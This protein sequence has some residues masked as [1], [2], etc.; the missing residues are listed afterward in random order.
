MCTSTSTAAA[1]GEQQPFFIQL[2]TLAKAE[3]QEVAAAE[4]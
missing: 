2:L 1:G 3:K 4:V